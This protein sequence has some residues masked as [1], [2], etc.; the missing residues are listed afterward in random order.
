MIDRK[1]L[2][3]NVF[4]P[5][6]ETNKTKLKTNSW[7]SSTQYLVDPVIKNENIYNK[8]PTNYLKAIKINMDLSKDQKTILNKWFHANTCMYNKTLNYINNLL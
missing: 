6:L 7:F 8:F 2:F 3:T 4:K 5:I 1:Q